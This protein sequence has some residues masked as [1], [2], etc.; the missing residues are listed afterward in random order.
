VSCAVEHL[1]AGGCA[2]LCTGL[3]RWRVTRPAPHTRRED[4]SYYVDWQVLEML[5]EKRLQGFYPPQPAA[6]AA[7]AAPTRTSTRRL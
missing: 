6:A 2:A 7:A 3:T 1:W 4:F 5:R